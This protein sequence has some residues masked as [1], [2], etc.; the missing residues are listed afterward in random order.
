[1]RKT[2]QGSTPSRR[3]KRL[4]E[5]DKTGA[6]RPEGDRFAPLKER[7]RAA[8][9]GVPVQPLAARLGFSPGS[10]YNWLSGRSA[11]TLEK[12]MEFAQATGVRAAWLVSGEGPMRG[13]APE[14]YVLPRVEQPTEKAPIAFEQSFLKSL[15]R[16]FYGDGFDEVRLEPLLIKADD[17]SMG[18]SIKRGDW[19]LI[20]WVGTTVSAQSPAPKDGIYYLGTRQLRRLQWTRRGLTVKTDSK[21]SSSQHFEFENAPF[22]IGPML[23]HGEDGSSNFHAN[24]REV[25]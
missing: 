22:I 12:L 3:L 4:Q 16:D 5:A 19:C 17:D 21:P 11:P 25:R 2:A 13:E 23:W 20:N 8:T 1:M 15:A 18:P 14:G 6:A 10:F 7:I 24:R 9:G